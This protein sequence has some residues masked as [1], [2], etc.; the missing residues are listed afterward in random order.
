MEEGNTIPADAKVRFLTEG[1]SDFRAD[2]Y[3]RKI[4]G[5]YDDKDGSKVNP[6][7]KSLVLRVV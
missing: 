1:Q 4:L 7:E 2:F 3:P 5:S 6:N